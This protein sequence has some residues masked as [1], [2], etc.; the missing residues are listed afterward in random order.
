MNNHVQQHL[1]YDYTEIL[2]TLNMF[3]GKT[4]FLSI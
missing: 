4:Y 3:M 1:Y 2:Y